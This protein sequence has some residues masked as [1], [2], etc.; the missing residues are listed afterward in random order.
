VPEAAP[1]PP[2]PPPLAPEPVPPPPPPPQPPPAPPPPPPAP[3]APPPPAPVAAGQRA[4]IHVGGELAG[5]GLVD[6]HRAASRRWEAKT[7]LTDLLVFAVSRALR[8]V[9]ELNGVPGGTTAETVDLALA[10]AGPD[11]TVWPVFRGAD[12]LDLLQI[13]AERERLT[14]A[15]RTGALTETDRANASASLSNLGGYPVDVHVP[16][17]PGPQI[18]RVTVGRVLEKPIS[19]QR[20][21]TIRPRV[22]FSLAI[23]ASAAD[24]EAGGR[25]L[26][27]LQRRLNDLAES[28]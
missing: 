10:A 17:E 25:F 5:D 6:A 7:T 15:A 22:W 18:V 12:A 16:A 23:E 24:A 8:D 26:A 14:E 4:T 11:G 2:P 20:M 27:A 9:P 21:L 28:I 19:F 1:P 13:S 3:V